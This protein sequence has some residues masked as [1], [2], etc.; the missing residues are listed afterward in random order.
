MFFD[1]NS[2]EPNSYSNIDDKKQKI[3]IKIQDNSLNNFNL[4]KTR[5]STDSE[6]LSKEFQIS[7]YSN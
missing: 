2:F 5:I 7:I 6:I 4:D 3:V 1:I